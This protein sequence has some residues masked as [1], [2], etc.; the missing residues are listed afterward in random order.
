M[1]SGPC[2]WFLA[3]LMR[4]SAIRGGISLSSALTSLSACLIADCWS[5]ES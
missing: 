2:I 4:D 5:A 3:W 1:A